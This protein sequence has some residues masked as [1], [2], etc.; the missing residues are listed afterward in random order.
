[1]WYLIAAV[2]FGAKPLSEKVSRA[3]FLLYILFLQLASAHHLLVEPGLSSE[4]KIFNTSYAMYLAVLGSHHLLVEPGLSSE[5]KI[6]NT[7]YAMYLAVLGSMI[8][9]LTV[10]GSIEAAQRKKGLTKGLFEW[11]RKAPWG[12]P[13]FSGMF[14]SL[15]MFG[16]LGGIS[17]VVM[18]TEQIN[19]IIHNTLYVPG[20]FHGTVVAGTTL[21]FMALTYCSAPGPGGS[22][23]S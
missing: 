23:C 22:P 9:G 3:A 5:Y 21:A 17:G 7:S 16:F 20:H 11:L 1:V 14:L 10:P 19:L 4:Y 12:N 8:H 2:V 15:L 18:G 13:A 6:F